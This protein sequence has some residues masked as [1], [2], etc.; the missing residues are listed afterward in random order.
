MGKFLPLSGSFLRCPE[1]GA[2]ASQGSCCSGGET[3][4]PC[5]S[6]LQRQRL[7]LIPKIPHVSRD[8]CCCQGVTHVSRDRPSH[9]VLSLMGATRLEPSRLMKELYTA[10][11]DSQID[12]GTGLSSPEEPI[13]VGRYSPCLWGVFSLTDAPYLSRCSHPPLPSLFL[14][15]T[16]VSGLLSCP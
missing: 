14:P 16:P 2:S 7:V 10:Y 1:Y 5:S 13:C 6:L 11:G 3:I 9:R 12:G 4:P 8:R 15:S